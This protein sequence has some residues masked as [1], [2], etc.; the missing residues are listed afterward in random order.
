[1]AALLKANG[2]GCSVPTLR[3]AFR[4]ELKHGRG[5]TVA[6]LAGRM[7]AHERQAGCGAPG[8]GAHSAAGDG[9]MADPIVFENVVSQPRATA[10]YAAPPGEPSAHQLN[11]DDP[12]RAAPRGK[13]HEPISHHRRSARQPVV[14]AASTVRKIARRADVGMAD[15]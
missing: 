13:S 12:K 8:V 6:K 11:M 2:A 7:L 10:P 3:K 14:A 9:L 4:A 1:M 5:L 15:D